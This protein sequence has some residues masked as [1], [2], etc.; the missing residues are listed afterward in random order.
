[1]GPFLQLPPRPSTAITSP[2]G[3]IVHLIQRE[4]SESFRSLW[5]AIPRDAAQCSAAFRLATFTVRI[6]S[7]SEI[8]KELDQ[9]DLE[10]MFYFL[11]LV[12]QLIDDDLSI[13]NCNGITGLELADQREEYAEIVFDG[14]K[15]LSNWIRSKEP[16]SFS[17][18]VTISS[19]FTSFWEAK[20]EALGGMSP[21]DYR[22]GEA[23][24][25]I[26]TSVDSSSVSKSSDEVAKLCREAR[27][28][29]ALRSAAYF[30]V[31]R[32]SILSN[33]VGN[34]VCNELVAD[35]TGLKP[36][37]ERQDGKLPAGMNSIP[38]ANSMQDCESWR[39]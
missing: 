25:K 14:R 15:V 1:M 2:L 5:L 27:T 34:R 23:F 17:P 21:V 4:I 33:T 20:L 36:Q 32:S 31:L 12:I 8:V 37:D 39:S 10:T 28:A 24:V 22:S 19:L 18:D 13:E 35:S 3:G 11:P 16:V 26:M 29:N 38:S 7:S 9:E 6:L 30:S